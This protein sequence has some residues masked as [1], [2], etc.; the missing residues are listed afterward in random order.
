MYKKTGVNH[1]YATLISS[2]KGKTTVCGSSI[3]VRRSLVATNAVHVT[4]N[5]HIH[6]H[7]NS[8][9]ASRELPRSEPQNVHAL[10]AERLC[11]GCRMSMLCLQNVHALSVHQCIIYCLPISD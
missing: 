3:S 11:P 8:I 6:S 4:S 1:Q 7:K 2:N 5:L 10:S 9:A